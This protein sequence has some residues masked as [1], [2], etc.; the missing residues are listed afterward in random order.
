MNSHTKPIT[1]FTLFELITL[2]AIIAVLTS[3]AVPVY[4]TY[5]PRIRLNGAVRMVMVDLMSARMKAIKLNTRTQVFF[6]NGHQYLICDDA[7]HDKTVENGEGA[8]L[9]RDIQN[10]FSDVTMSANNQPKFLPRGSAT[11][12]ATITLSNP[13]GEKLVTVAITGRIKLK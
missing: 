7:N 8:A 2:M 5:I 13:G 12:M 11:N 3:V 1:G 10:E 9:M 4:L 6:I